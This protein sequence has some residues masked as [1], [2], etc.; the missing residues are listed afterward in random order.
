MLDLTQ[1]KVQSKQ[2]SGRLWL[3]AGRRG[4][5]LESVALGEQVRAINKTRLVRQLGHLTPQSLRA[6]GAALKVVLDL[7]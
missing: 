3:L 6:I 1:R 2:E 5:K 7:P 4:L